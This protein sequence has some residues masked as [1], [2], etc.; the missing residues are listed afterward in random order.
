MKTIDEILR[1]CEIIWP[2]ACWQ[3]LLGQNGVGYGKVRFHGR[4]YLVH[5]LI[6]EVLV[7]PIPDGYHLHHLCHN[8]LCCN[9]EHLEP[10]TSKEHLFR[11]NT[12]TVRNINATH[13]PQG[14]PYSLEN[15][16]YDP[17]GGRRCRLCHRLEAQAYRQRKKEERNSS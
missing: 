4:D 7:G 13:C 17:T 5:R 16:Y 2:T 6:Y 9:P 15:T 3:W 14:H 10:V 12:I 11:G 8:T 1:Y